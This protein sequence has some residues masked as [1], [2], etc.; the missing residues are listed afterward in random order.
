MI[1]LHA[2]YAQSSHGRI[3]GSEASG[4]SVAGDP[5]VEA[6]DNMRAVARGEGMKKSSE[7]GYSKTVTSG[8][9]SSSVRM[10]RNVNGRTVTVRSN[11]VTGE[12]RDFSRQYKSSDRAGICKGVRAATKHA[13]NQTCRAAGTAKRVLARLAESDLSHEPFILPIKKD[14]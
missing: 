10:Q 8:S 3:E 1:Q 14:G 11:A 13:A 5:I 7:L 9:A 4:V 6:N 12:S 2:R